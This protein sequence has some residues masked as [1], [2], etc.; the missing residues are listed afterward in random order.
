[1]G[2]RRLLRNAPI[3]EALIDIK[4]TPVSGADV[5]A[6]AVSV[7]EGE[8]TSA[9]DV[10]DHTFELSL[11]KPTEPKALFSTANPGKRFDYPDQNQVLQLRPA[12]FTFSRLPPYETWEQMR[13]AA[14]PSWRRY[15]AQLNPEFVTRVALRYI[16]ALSLPLPLDRFE[17]YLVAPPSVPPGLPNGLSGFLSRL[18]IPKG[19][20]TALIT[21]SVEGEVKAAGSGKAL[22][23]LLDIDVS[24][25]CRLPRDEFGKVDVVLERLREYKNQIFFSFL[26]DE[27]LE[28][29][30]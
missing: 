20:D 10:F 25:H 5:S 1:V 7:A 28:M 9:F 14:L 24:H 21:Q 2:I 18:V 13:D 30:A 15:S 3:Q 29:F 23:V 26:T 16:N 6:I 8:P 19:P 22:K 12:S 17:K 11:E 27:A 4:F